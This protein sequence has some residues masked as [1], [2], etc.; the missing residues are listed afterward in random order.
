MSSGPAGCCPASWL[1]SPVLKGV[2]C[3][4]IERLYYSPLV[5][6][7][8]LLPSVCICTQAVFYFVVKG[9]DCFVECR[10]GRDLR[11]ELGVICGF[12]S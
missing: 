4:T 5:G 9:G 1:V 10:F 7:C 3:H 8:Q 2:G 11:M 6:E 12:A